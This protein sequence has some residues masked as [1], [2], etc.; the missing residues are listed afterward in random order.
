M[1]TFFTEIQQPDWYFWGTR[2]GEPVTT[3]T[4]LAMTVTCALCCYRLRGLTITN[5]PAL[6]MYYFFIA[7]GISSLTG[8][9]LGHAFLYKLGN[10]GKIPGWEMSMVAAFALS[11]A[12]M[13]RFFETPDENSLYRA[14]TWANLAALLTCNLF[15][16]TSMKFVWVEIYTAIGLLLFMSNFE[17]RLHKKQAN[18]VSILLLK[19]MI[20]MIAAVIFIILKFSVGPWLNYF[21]MSHLFICATIVYFYRALLEQMG[22]YYTPPLRID[23]V[24]K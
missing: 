7:F 4:G 14:F 11:Q 10:I 17:Y 20:P 15:M 3:I 1:F 16:L 8:A 9:V 24:Q 2:I 5:R 13:L 21:D 23:K 6:Y 12:S 19:G 18:A 22:A